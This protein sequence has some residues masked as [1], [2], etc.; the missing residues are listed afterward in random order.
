VPGRGAEHL[1]VFPWWFHLAE[2]A[3]VGLVVILVVLLVVWA[4]TRRRT[5]VVPPAATVTPALAEVDLRYARGEIGHEDYLQRRANLLGQPAP[6]PSG[7]TPTA[8]SPPESPG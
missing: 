3:I 7:P 4:T 2:I 5:P 8:E 1:S 6:P